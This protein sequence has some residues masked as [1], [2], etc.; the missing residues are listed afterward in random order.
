LDSVKFVEKGVWD[1][2]A[3]SDDLEFLLDDVDAIL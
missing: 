2:K 1:E 3:T